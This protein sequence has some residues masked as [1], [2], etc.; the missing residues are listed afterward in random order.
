MTDLECQC[1]LRELVQWMAFEVT[2]ALTAAGE[3]V[4]EEDRDPAVDIYPS[5]L[6]LCEALSS[7]E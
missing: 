7:G 6:P 2:P 1:E 3:A 4:V 5:S